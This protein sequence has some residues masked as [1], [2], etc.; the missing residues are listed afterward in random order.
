MTYTK[1][2][3]VCS[4]VCIW[5]RQQSRLAHC[6]VV[7]VHYM[8]AS[9]TAVVDALCCAGS[10]A[11]SV[12]SLAYYSFATCELALYV[13]CISACHTMYDFNISCVQARS[14][15]IPLRVSCI[16]PGVV[17]TEFAEVSSYGS[18]EDA[19]KRYAAFKCLQANDIAQAVVWCLT[20][21]DHMD[22]N[23]ICIR[24]TAQ[25]T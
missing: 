19:K 5:S 17:E 22:I 20:A 4:D 1:M 23:D 24:P 7:H 12:T 3:S 15:N 21:P 2:L 25:K 18:K 16:S 13:L 9:H 11:A 6:C 10:F 14:R 8:F